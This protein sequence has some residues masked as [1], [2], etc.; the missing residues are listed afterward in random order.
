MVLVVLAHPYLD[1]SRA[2]RALL[3]QVERQSGVRVRDLYQLYPTFSIDVAAEQRALVEAKVIVFQHPMYWYSVPGLLKH[4]FDKVL[5]RGF[6]YGDGEGALKG[7]KC[8][9]AITTG[10]DD[11]AF[12]ADG[13]HGQELD[14]FLPVLRQTSVFCG[15][16][17]LPPMIVSGA[18]RISD[19]L[20]QQEAERY[21]QRIS[22]L[23][24]L[25]DVA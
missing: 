6:A 25:T 21:G 1:R 23:R 18:H 19:T 22:E 15:M 10:G 2:N 9:F 24:A 13:I 7:K 12:S 16:E 3:D 8:L 14:A 17:F 5:A 4:W 20:L 11:K